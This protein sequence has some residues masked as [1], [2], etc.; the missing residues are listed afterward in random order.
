MVTKYSISLA[1]VESHA[2]LT[3]PGTGL[4]GTLHIC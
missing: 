4:S 1:V 3:V 2:T